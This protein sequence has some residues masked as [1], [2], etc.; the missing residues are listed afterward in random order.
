M[1]DNVISNK[2]ILVYGL[3]LLIIQII[4]HGVQK[5]LNQ[6]LL[7]QEVLHHHQHLLHLVIHQKEEILSGNHINN[8]KTKY[9][10]LIT[11]V[12]ICTC[13]YVFSF[14]KIVLPVSPVVHNALCGV[15]EHCEMVREFFVR[16]L[17]STGVLHISHTNVKVALGSQS[18]FILVLVAV[19]VLCY[20]L[21]LNKLQYIIQSF[22]VI[23]S[24]IS[25]DVSLVGLMI[26]NC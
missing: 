16:V 18:P 26:S 12:Q 9:F 14:C 19:T 10:S 21:H 24:V 6:H 17:C 3:K 2:I 22:L 4:C 15:G 20:K 25:S 7:I 11:H 13:V 5:V 23:H 1:F 8:L